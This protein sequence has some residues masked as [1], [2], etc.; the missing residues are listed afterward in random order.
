MLFLVLFCL[1]IVIHETFHLVVARS[2][3][4]RAE[5]FYG[6]NLLNVYGYVHVEPPAEGFI[7]TVLLFGAGGLGTALVFFI[8]WSAIEDILAKIL[9]SFFTPMQLAYGVLEP[10]YGLRLIQIDALSIWPI[11]AGLI[12]LVVFRVIYWRRGLW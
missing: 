4:Y 1:S 7:P 6:I 5:V 11:L 10:L 2:L 12:A 8:L 9:L 3:G